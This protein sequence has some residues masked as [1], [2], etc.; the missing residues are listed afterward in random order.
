MTAPL[1]A[2]L[3]KALDGLA[4]RAVVT[5]QN[6]ANSGTAG[7]RP[8]QV[9]FEDALQVAAGAERGAVRGLTPQV[10]ATTNGSPLRLDLELATSA[11]TALR[12]SALIEVLDRQLQLQSL[13]LS[14]SR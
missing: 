11:A 8:L 4:M 1:E 12:Y 6:I 5:A 13:A 9:T 7:Y 3:L 14:G 10:S 2:I